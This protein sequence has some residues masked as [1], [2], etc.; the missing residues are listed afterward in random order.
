[1]NLTTSISFLFFIIPS[2]YLAQSSEVQAQL[3]SL[4]QEVE[5][6]LDT[7][8]KIRLIN[9]MVALYDRSP[10]R[11]TLALQAIRFAERC[12]YHEDAIAARI[13]MANIYA[14]WSQYDSRI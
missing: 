1:M 2:F 3:D 7:I 6:E 12:Q 11:K 13:N 4:S 9:K 5:V 8:Q 10:K 14:N